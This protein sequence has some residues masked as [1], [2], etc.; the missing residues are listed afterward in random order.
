MAQAAQTPKEFIQHRWNLHRDAFRVESFVPPGGGTGFL[1]VD[2]IVQPPTYFIVTSVANGD[3]RAIQGDFADDRSSRGKPE[4]IAV[5]ALNAELASCKDVPVAEALRLLGMSGN[6]PG[7]LVELSVRRFATSLNNPR[8]S[9]RLP[10]EGLLASE[11]KRFDASGLDKIKESMD[12]GALKALSATESFKWRDYSYYSLQGELGDIR[13]AA[14][15]YFPVFAAFIVE[16]PSV[17]RAIDAQL[18]EKHR[19]EAYLASPEHREKLSAPVEKKGETRTLEE[20]MR[21]E[22]RDP[23]AAWQLSEKAV[24]QA[25]QNGF[26]R[27]DKEQPR[28]ANH[29]FANLRG[30]AWVPNGVGVERIVESLNELPADW[31]PKTQEDWD[32]FCDLSSTVGNLIPRLTDTPLRVLYE[33]C[34]GKWDNLRER[35]MRSFSDTRPPE[36]AGEEDVAHLETSIDWD[37]LKA[38]PR[39]KVAAA[40][41]EAVARIVDLSP[42]IVV[43]DVENWVSQRILP[44]ISYQ[45][46]YNACIEVDEMN[47]V[48]ARKIILPLAANEA[49]RRSGAQEHP[50]AEQHHVSAREAASRILFPG[51]SAVRLLEMTRA[52]INHAAEIGAA[53]EDPETETKRM[54]REERQRAA[55]MAVTLTA[56]GIDPNAEIPEN[57][58]A[59]LSAVVQAPNGVYVVP[60]TDPEMLADE[61]RGYTE[62]TRDN[63]DGSKGLKICV[64]HKSMGY[65]ELCRTNGNHI[66]SFRTPGLDGKVFTRLSC[67]QLNAL[68]IGSNE[69]S[70]IQHRGPSNGAVPEE[71]ERAW[72]WYK[73]SVSNGDIALNHDEIRSRM[74]NV[75]AG[76]VDEV[77][78]I[79]GYDWKSRTRITHAMAPWAPFVDKKRRKM[80]VD[81]FAQDSEIL[82]VV[83]TIDPQNPGTML[84][85]R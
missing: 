75:R 58:W 47:S 22:G 82:G 20:W 39:E 23:N 72:N 36:G 65:A 45:A 48:F 30:I 81:Q 8:L 3:I 77:A 67:L 21:I 35:M 17:R 42:Q 83:E 53:G 15:A 41:I 80:D 11:S 32:A 16:R 12:S 7:G 68:K 18:Q 79:C 25:I 33:G 4:H 76:K 40:A 5:A 52:F 10:R 64:G 44:D 43:A 59:P 14:A 66:V 29:V 37:A 55:M 2:R 74:A 46:I 28:V 27:D 50:L 61:G 13:R 69:L 73:N 19:A 70:K 6:G 31:A 63:N 49:T 56:I 54:A 85:N 78:L 71:A 1:A 26:G 51:K 57:G 84:M 9:A 24:R 62:D 38:L 60:L 34:G